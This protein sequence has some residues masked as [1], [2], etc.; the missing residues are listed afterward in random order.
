MT[1]EAEV[2]RQVGETV[3]ADLKRAE[4]IAL[5]VTLVLLVLVFAGLAAAMLPLFVGAP[6][7]AQQPSSCSTS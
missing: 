7:G 6:D 5:P 2:F 3:E 1:G 4:L